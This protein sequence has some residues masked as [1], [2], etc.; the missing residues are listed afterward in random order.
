MNLLNLSQLF[1]HKV[2]VYVCPRLPYSNDILCD[3]LPHCSCWSELLVPLPTSDLVVIFVFDVL[4]CSMG[5]IRL[6][7][8]GIVIRWAQWHIIM[9][10]NVHAVHWYDKVFVLCIACIC[11]FQYILPVFVMFLARSVHGDRDHGNPTGFP[12][13][14][15]WMLREYRRMDLTIAGFPRGWILLRREPRIEPFT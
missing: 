1:G 8:N 6:I 3:F 2:E 7:A 4:D 5:I 13:V 9:F 12:R 14:W 10:L 11:I 15:V